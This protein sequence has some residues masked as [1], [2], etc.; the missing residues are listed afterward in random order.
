VASFIDSTKSPPLKMWKRIEDTKNERR[1]DFD[2]LFKK[3]RGHLHLVSAFAAIKGVHFHAFLT[4]DY[5]VFAVQS[6]G[7]AVQ[8]YL[9]R[10]LPC[11]ISFRC[12]SRLITS[13]STLTLTLTLT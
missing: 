9:A 10:P 2:S 4:M 1:D 11:R 5:E 6:R 12:S 13:L 8:R 3:V 7:G